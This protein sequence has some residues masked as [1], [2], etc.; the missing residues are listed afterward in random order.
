MV[1]KEKVGI[2]LEQGKIVYKNNNLI[3]TEHPREREY[4]SSLINNND[5]IY[6]IKTIGD[7]RPTIEDVCQIVYYILHNKV[8]YSKFL[9]YKRQI[10]DAIHK[11]EDK[12]DSPD[13]VVDVM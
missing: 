9:E 10:L 7:N 5:R 12:F 1:K 13:K 8:Y 3:I 11:A 6:H 2:E 4:N